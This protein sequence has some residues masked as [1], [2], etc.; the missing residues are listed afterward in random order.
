MLLVNIAA[1]VTEES[2]LHSLMPAPRRLRLRAATDDLHQ[3]LDARVSNASFLATREGYCDYLLRTY[4]ARSAVEAA[5]DRSGA[6]N[7]YAAWPDRR[8]GAAMALDLDDMGIELPVE[9]PALEMTLGEGGIWGALYV[10]EGSTIGARLIARE[11][12]K[13][14]MTDGHGARHLSVQAANSRAFRQFIDVLEAATL[15]ADGEAE[16]TSAAIETFSCFQRAYAA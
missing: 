9:P 3:M 4:L 11:V 14:G 15:D 13:I 10:L 16:C 12:E 6:Q 5:L 1:P 8:I 7:V 2:I